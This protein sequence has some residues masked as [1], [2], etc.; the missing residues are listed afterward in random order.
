MIAKSIPKAAEAKIRLLRPH[1]GEAAVLQDFA[2]NS[3]VYKRFGMDGHNGLD[4]GLVM[5]PVLAAHD[6]IIEFAGDGGE[7][8]MLGSAAGIAVLLLADGYRTEYAHLMRAYVRTGDSVAAGDVIGI[9]GKTGATTGYHLHFGL[10]LSPY[11]PTNGYAGRTD[12]A[13]YLHTPTPDPIETA[14]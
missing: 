10:I 11:T 2:E 14:S 5:Q 3:T 4:I 8:P 12:P 9:S 6:G 1:Y 7:W 13:P